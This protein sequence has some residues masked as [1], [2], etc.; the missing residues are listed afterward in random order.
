MSYSLSG[1]GATGISVPGATTLTIAGTAPDPV[2]GFTATAGDVQV[3]LSWTNPTVADLASLIVSATA[4]GSA[5]D[6]TGGTSSISSL[7]IAVEA[8]SDGNDLVVTAT[9]GMLSGQAGNITV[10]GLS[11]G[12]AYTF[13]IVA[14][15][16]SGN[17]STGL[18]ERVTPVPVA[19]IDAD[20]NTI[21]E[22]TAGNK[23]T[24]TITLSSMSSSNIDVNVVAGDTGLT[25][26]DRATFGHGTYDATTNVYDYSVTV[27]GAEV[28]SEEFMVT[29]PAGSTV[30]TFTVTA[31]DDPLSD[32]RGVRGMP[33][34][35]TP[36][37]FGIS[38]SST[39]SGIYC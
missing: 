20:I 19:S 30:T 39:V 24:L 23:A 8:T 25:E 6:L 32:G 35:S 4:G 9:S 37:T 13:T 5:V 10:T 29:V 26:L 14:V 17:E 38:L 16:N 27:A 2:T 22:A 15:D 33:T 18:T 31:V 34:V 3:T 1:S 7:A 21:T 11:N 12:T 36:E 28:S